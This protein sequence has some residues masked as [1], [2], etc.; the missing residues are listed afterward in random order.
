MPAE[1]D[2]WER[3]ARRALAGVGDPALGEWVEVGRV[4]LHLRRRLT[5]AEQGDLVVR[6]VRHT[7]EAAMRAATVARW[8]PYGFTDT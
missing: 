2:E 8:N 5:A 4:A 7:T 6:D 3:R 1:H